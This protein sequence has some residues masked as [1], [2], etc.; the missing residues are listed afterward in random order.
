MFDGSVNTENLCIRFG[1]NQTGKAVTG[2]T[3]Y[4]QTVSRILLV[5]LNSKWSMKRPQALS[6]EV[7]TQMLDAR[8]VTDC[9]MWIRPACPRVSGVL[10]SLAVDVIQPLSLS[11]VRLEIVI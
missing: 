7:I 10:A 6:R 2:I 5:E 9:G 11:V 3:T 8:F 4:A 1:I